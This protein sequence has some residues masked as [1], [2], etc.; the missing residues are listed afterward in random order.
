M[1][2]CSLLP[3]ALVCVSAAADSPGVF[4]DTIVEN[5]C[6][7]SRNQDEALKAASMDVEISGSLPKLKKHGKLHALRRIS[8]LGRITYEMLRFEGDNTVKKEVIARY[9]TA[10][11]EAQHDASVAVTPQNYKFKYKGQS[12]LDGR[13][14][15]M[16]Q[17]SPK[18]KRQGL[19]KGEIWIDAATY[20]RVQESGYLV[21]SPSLL[22][23]KIAFVRKYEIRDGISV[24]RQV[25]S[26]TDTWLVGKA[27]LTVD[28]TNF[29]I[30]GRKQGV[31][32]D[33]EGQ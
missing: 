24:P 7:A 10:E 26:V 14:V 32:G 12:Q 28:Y 33:T 4:P 21:K 6:V 27:E 29:S 17:V 18:Q 15:H 11:S 13:D 31:A 19:F 9:L 5:Y 25:Q 23:R 30:D 16:F 20:L 8:S 3:L 1:K 2:V 22:I